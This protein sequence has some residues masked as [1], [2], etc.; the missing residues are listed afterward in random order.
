MAFTPI[1]SSSIFPGKPI[2]SEL[3]T[4]IKDNFDDHESRISALSIGATVIELFNE[5]I[6][7]N[8]GYLPTGIA[9]K[10]SL[11]PCNITEIAIQLFEKAP[12][13]T[14]SLT[15]DIKK[16]TTTNPAG[17]TSVLSILPTLN[18][19]TAT[20]Y[21]RTTGTINPANQT[22]AAGNILRFDITAVPA[23]LLR[24]RLIVKAEL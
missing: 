13:T 12:A 18:M 16:N 20:N 5:E 14:G 7:L 4:T 10:E 23:G 1:N 24:F 15:I 2:K 22:L 17:F 21:Q 9:Y 3:F 19:T 6:I 8:D 11:Q